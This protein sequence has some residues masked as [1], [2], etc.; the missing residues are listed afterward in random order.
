MA[1]ILETLGVPAGAIVLESRSRNTRENAVATRELLAPRGVR[2]ILL[3]TS[4]LHM[5]R[6]V[7]LFERQGFDVIAAPAD[8]WYVPAGSD[9]EAPSAWGWI[10]D[11]LPDAEG[12]AHSTEA[13]REYLALAYYRG[14][15]LVD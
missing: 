13:L 12:L 10:L 2:R 11:V 4:A 14:R 15:G 7:A 9:G 6:A 8:F 3:V 1:T 5:P